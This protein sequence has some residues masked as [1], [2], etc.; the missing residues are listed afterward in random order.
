[1]ASTTPTTFTCFPNLPLELQKTIWEAAAADLP[2]LDVQR[3]TAEIT[4]TERNADSDKPQRP[5]LCFTPH[6]DFIDVTSGHR[7]LLRACRES[8]KAAQ[9]Q[10]DCLLPI[11]Y[12]TTDATGSLVTHQVCVPF[13]SSGY[14][15]VS[16]LSLAIRQATEGRGARGS[17]LLHSH[18]FGNIRTEIEGLDE[19]IS[20]TKKLTIV[21]D[22]AQSEFNP[23]RHM[24]EYKAFQLVYSRMTNLKKVPVTT[25]VVP[26]RRRHLQQQDSDRMHQRVVV[27][28]QLESWLEPEEEERA[29]WSTLFVY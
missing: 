20:L 14:F 3:F 23:R 24:F 7:G 10:I 4:L 2:V 13:D 6:S 26:G 9:K 22:T 19:V 28:I 25:E 18:S 29:N 1:M 21:P 27:G 15:C 11:H 5:L 17:R 16:G 8:R 12:L